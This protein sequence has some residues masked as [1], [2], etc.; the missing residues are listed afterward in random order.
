[1]DA[2]KKDFA[3]CAVEKC[4]F[5]SD[6]GYDVCWKHRPPV[7]IVEPAFR[8]MRS[9]KQNSPTS[10]TTPPD[11]IDFYERIME[12]KKDIQSCHEKYHIN[13]LDRFEHDLIQFVESSSWMDEF[14]KSVNDNKFY[15]LLEFPPSM[16]EYSK[17]FT[18]DEMTKIARKTRL[19]GPFI[20]NVTK[21]GI[22]AMIN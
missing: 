15:I 8:R 12:R 14:E 1:M 22:G 17:N 9:P 6:P 3:Q 18:S 11:V 2:C 5:N 19:F 20:V 10:P 7:K 16:K 21:F 13:D 4:V